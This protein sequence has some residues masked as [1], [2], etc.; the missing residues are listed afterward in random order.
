[1]SCLSWNC[2]GLGYPRKVQALKKNVSSKVPTFVFLCEMKLLRREL[3]GVSRKLGFSCCFCVDYCMDR[4]GRRGGLGLCWNDDE[5]L[6]VQS[7]SSN[8]IDVIV[9]GVSPW[10]FFGIYGFPEDNNKWK[11]WRMIEYLA[12]LSS[13][14]W[15][16][17]G[18]FNEILYDF[19]KHWGNL[20]REYRMI[21]FRDCLEK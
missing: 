2:R 8:H 18:D 16:L 14:P 10:R 21:E 7:F 6:T 20:R 17:L 9:G 12:N 13:L 4:G 5:L 15:L 19:E 1:M 3:E 11:T